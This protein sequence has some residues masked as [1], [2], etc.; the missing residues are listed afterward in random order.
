MLG[1]E[2][3]VR[4]LR[5]IVVLVVGAVVLTGCRS[6][7][8]T[9]IIRPDYTPA[10]HNYSPRVRV[11]TIY[12]T[13]AVESGEEVKGM[14]GEAL[15]YQLHSQGMLE[16][17]ISS[18][19]IVLTVKVREYE[20][21]NA[22]KRFLVPEWGKTVLDASYTLT[23]NKQQIGAGSVRSEIYSGFFTVGAWRSVFDD[24][25]LEMVRDIKEDLEQRRG[26]GAA[27]R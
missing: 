25:A 1:V 20:R 24:V 14:F 19:A 22:F 21:G 23:S 27:K 2:K 16:R 17:N 8:N 13:A 11:G 7:N 9:L 10:H 15:N 12:N 18:M 26:R 4:Y 3:I 5:G 6:V